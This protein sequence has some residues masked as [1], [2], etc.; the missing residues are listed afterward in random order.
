MRKKQNIIISL[1]LALMML[2]TVTGCGGG[3]ADSG[4]TKTVTDCIGREVQIPEKPE[5]VA[6]LYAT[7]AHMMAM[8]D[9]GDKIVGCPNGVKS[10]VLMQ[11]KYPEITE[12]STPHQEGS[13]NAE[14]LLATETDLALVSGSLASSEGEM[15]KLDDMGIPYV[16]IDYTSIDELRTAVRVAGEVFDKQEKAE[17]YISFFDDTLSMVDEKLEDVDTQEAPD[18]Y[19]SINEATR[20]DPEGTICSEIMERAKVKDISVEKGTLATG[21]NAYITLEELYNW[22]P[23]AIIAN[24]YSV[25]EY[26]MSDSKWEGLTAVKEKKVYT[27]PVGATRWCHPGSMEAHMG[28]LAVAVQFYPERFKDFDIKEYTRDYYKTYFDLDLDDQTLD[29]ILAGEGMRVSNSPE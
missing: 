7:A 16:V 3:T 20:T 28:V 15:E 11:M 13:V 9:E 10:D 22:D 23:D 19:H 14:E 25:T 6:C 21:K 1:I 12:T 29:K 27:L 18:V 17:Q 24:E 4:S 8:L 2:V 26:V 5:R